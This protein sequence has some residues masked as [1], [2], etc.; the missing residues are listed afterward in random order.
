LSAFC[1]VAACARRA[2]S[3]RLSCGRPA[4]T[5]RELWAKIAPDFRRHVTLGGCS[6]GPSAAIR[7]PFAERELWAKIAPD[8]RPHVT[9]GGCSA[10][11]R[12]PV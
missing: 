9:L 6:R 2:C 8:F 3:P 1:R 7:I 11:A 5:E 12:S 4:C 10:A